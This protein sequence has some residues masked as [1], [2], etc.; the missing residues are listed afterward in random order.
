MTPMNRTFA[1]ELNEFDI[2]AFKNPKDSSPLQN[3]AIIQKKRE[4]P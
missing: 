2:P 4:N 1:L 3:K